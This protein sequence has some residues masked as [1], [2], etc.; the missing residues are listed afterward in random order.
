MR[1]NFRPPELWL[2]SPFIGRYIATSVAVRDT[3]SAETS[4]ASR[5]M[6]LFAVACGLLVANAYFGSPQN[7]GASR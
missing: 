4:V 7:A 1:E 5:L 2:C 6:T 3:G